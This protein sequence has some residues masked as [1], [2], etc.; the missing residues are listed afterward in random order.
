MKRTLKEFIFVFSFCIFLSSCSSLK[1]IEGWPFETRLY[2]EK[3]PSFLNEELA[4][5]ESKEASVLFAE[6]TKITPRRKAFDS[7]GYEISFE[8]AEIYAMASALVGDPMS[9]FKMLEYLGYSIDR[10][11]FEKAVNYG[12]AKNLA[13]NG[14]YRKALRLF[15]KY[16]DYLDSLK[17]CDEMIHQDLVRFEIGDIG[18]AG[19]YVFYDKGYYSSGFLGAYDEGLEADGWRYLEAAPVDLGNF[20]Y[21]SRPQEAC[22]ILTGVGCGMYNTEMIV[23]MFGEEAVAAKECLDYSLNGYDDWFLPSKEELDL[24]YTN[25]HRV[26][27]GSFDNTVAYW[28][29]SYNNLFS[30]E[31]DI[32]FKSFDTGSWYLCDN[33]REAHMVRPIRAF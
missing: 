2:G 21:G 29:S 27:I 5:E 7:L 25:L 30:Y 32:L 14:N 23:S 1:R 12:E 28:S 13:L 26:G 15:Y 8:D 22:G 16:P 4:Y 9:E 11:L 6:L 17:I 31:Y 18:P 19:G 10:V 24:L 20:V 33:H 3:D